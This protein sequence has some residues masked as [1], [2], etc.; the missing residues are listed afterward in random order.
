MVYNG[1]WTGWERKRIPLWKQASRT[2]K[3]HGSRERGYT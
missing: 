1:Q 3:R 2:G